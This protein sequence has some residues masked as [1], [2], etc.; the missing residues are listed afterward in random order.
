M[1][2]AEQRSYGEA[3]RA[4]IAVA[5]QIDHVSARATDAID[6]AVYGLT[7]G[8]LLADD[9]SQPQVFPGDRSS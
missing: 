3:F 4:L 7:S 9:A 5:D 8:V 1:S 6:T 2:L